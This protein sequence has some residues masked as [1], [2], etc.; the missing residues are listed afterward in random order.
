MKSKGLYRD[1]FLH[2]D[3]L[4]MACI[5]LGVVGSL[6]TMEL[7]L[8]VFLYIT[9][10]II[11]YMFSEYLTHRFVFHIKAPKNALFLKLIKRLHYDHHKKPNDLKLLFLP[12]WYSL[13]S[14]FTLSLIFFI[15]TG[16]V[17]ATLSF[18]VG[19]LFM[20]FVYEWK[21]YVAHRPF[22]PKTRFGKW[23]KK[24]HVLH[25][26]KNENYWYGVSTPF[27]DVLFGTLKDEKNVET[28]QTAKDLE[29]RF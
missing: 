5:F 21:H 15:I 20:F 29:N 8:S 7:T 9:I 27:V 1:F 13:P 11:T 22:K 14:L 4:A 19:I 3:I 25:H 17:V 26:Y 16:S 12:I 23:L 24:T 28:S 10:G 18:T 2:F 6:L